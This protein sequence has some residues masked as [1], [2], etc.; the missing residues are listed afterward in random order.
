MK[1][2]Y[3]EYFGT[4]EKNKSIHLIY[5]VNNEKLANI[6]PKDPKWECKYENWQYKVKINNKYFRS[7]SIFMHSYTYVLKK[8]CKY[9]IQYKN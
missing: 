2:L 7:L 8:G 5:L 4:N 6:I 3:K 9:A 1:Y